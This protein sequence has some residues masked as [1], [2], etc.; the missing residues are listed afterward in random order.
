MKFTLVEFE[1]LIE[2]EADAGSKVKSS[3]AGV[4]VYEPFPNPLKE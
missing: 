2:N 3:N 4:T 1:L